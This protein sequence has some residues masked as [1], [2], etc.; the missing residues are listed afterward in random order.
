MIITQK[1]CAISGL[2]FEFSHI[3]HARPGDISL[4]L[5]K[6]N[7]QPILLDTSSQEFV[8][9]RWQMIMTFADFAIQ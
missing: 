8:Y 2:V 9:K 7:G 6:K 1:V 5:Y 3:E 4:L